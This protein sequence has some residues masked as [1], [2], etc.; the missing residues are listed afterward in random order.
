MPTLVPEGIAAQLERPDQAT[1]L[2]CDLDRVCRPWHRPTLLPGPS[3][4]APLDLLSNPISSLDSFWIDQ[5]EG[6]EAFFQAPP[7][8]TIEHNLGRQAEGL[9]SALS[10][11]PGPA[12]L[13][14]LCSACCWALPWSN[15]GGTGPHWQ[16]LCGWNCQRHPQDGYLL[17]VP[18]NS[19][20]AGTDLGA[21]RSRA[22]R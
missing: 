22:P 14:A 1:A 4:L 5:R 2:G 12:P 6:A 7:H 10:P 13:P 9:T 20:S 18:S 19:H 11:P 16:Q 21:V 15:Q 17:R 8:L 3:P